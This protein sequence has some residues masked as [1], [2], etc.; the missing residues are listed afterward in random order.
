ME[1]MHTDFLAICNIVCQYSLDKLH[2]LYSEYN[3]IICDFKHM[4]ISST[5]S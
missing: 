5:L 1:H 2:T 4:K 3:L